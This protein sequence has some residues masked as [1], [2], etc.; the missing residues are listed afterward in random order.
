MGM[1][2]KTLERFL[3]HQRTPQR[4]EDHVPQCVAYVVSDV[5][6]DLLMFAAQRLRVGGRL[7]YW[8][9][10]MTQQYKDEDLPLHP[11]LEIIA[12][13]VQPLTFKWERRLI[14]MVKTIKYDPNIHDNL[15][16]TE[17][18]ISL[19]A[20]GVWT[21]CQTRSRF[22]QRPFSSSHEN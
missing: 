8:L 13:S 17:N 15:E 20:G 1:K 11:C 12:N 21:T 4:G 22:D 3:K 10:T 14:T 7:V 2:R 9:P 6:R 16:V 18:L 5:M 19:A